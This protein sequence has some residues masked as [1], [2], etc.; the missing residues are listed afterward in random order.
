MATITVPVAGDEVS[1]T[2]FGAPVA[3]QL[4]TNT[5]DI[6]A[7]NT[8]L[9]SL[10][11]RVGTARLITSPGQSGFGT[12]ATDITGL[13]ITFTADATK[14]HR[15]TLS[16]NIVKD[17]TAGYGQ[18]MISRSDNTLLHTYAQTLASSG[19]GA[20]TLIYEAPPGTFSGT[21]TIKGRLQCAAGT[22]AINQGPDAATLL[23][24]DEVGIT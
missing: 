17:A 4:N 19:Y 15:V 3:N 24:V 23:T 2:T 7:I 16:I 1:V 11:K 12:T 10:T 5:N 8:A 20:M 13:A 9:R 18:P 6:A 21:T 22:V 14:R